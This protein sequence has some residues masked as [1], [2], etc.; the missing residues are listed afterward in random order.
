MD[1]KKVV[2]N[3]T[4][5]FGTIFIMGGVLQVF[6]PFN[7][8]LNKLAAHKPLEFSWYSFLWCGFGIYFIT[9][10]SGL[11]YHKE[12]ARKIVVIFFIIASCSA[13]ILIISEIIFGVSSGIGL[14]LLFLG[15]IVNSFVVF[16]FTRPSVTGKFK[17]RAI[18]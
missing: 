4:K 13:I 12:W 17:N 2:S 15:L 11:V 3:G 8:M 10:G 9:C 1:N 14:L 16:F 18:S 5:V 6:R 7:D